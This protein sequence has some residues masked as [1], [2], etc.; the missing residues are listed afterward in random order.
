MSESRV[1]LS[2]P[3]RAVFGTMER[4]GDDGG[5]TVSKSVSDAIKAGY[6]HFDTAELHVYSTTK[7]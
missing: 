2:A 4:A 1:P 7:V 3:P 6:R 5:Y